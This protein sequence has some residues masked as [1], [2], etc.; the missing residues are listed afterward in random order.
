MKYIYSDDSE[1][2]PINLGKCPYFSRVTTND[3]YAIRFKNKGGWNDW[4]FPTIEK[5]EEIFEKLLTLDIMQNVSTI[6]KL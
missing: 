4:E 3:Y 2:A 1:H 6:T 5:R